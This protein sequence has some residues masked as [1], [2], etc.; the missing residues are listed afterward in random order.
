MKQVIKRVLENQLAKRGYLMI[1]QQPGYHYVPDI[2]GRS[3]HK[4]IDPRN[5]QDFEALASPI[6][7]APERKSY[8]YYDRLYI[9]YQSL[10][11][12]RHL[13]GGQM[14]EVGVFRGGG[15]YFMASVIRHHFDYTPTFYAIDT[16]E[17]HP[18]DINPLVDGYHTPGN[19]NKTSYET[20]KE[21]LSEFENVQVLKGRFEDR[22]NELEDQRFAFVHLDVDIYYPTKAGLDFFSRRLLSG[23]IIVVDDYGFTTCAGAK[24]ATDEFTA[25]HPEFAQFHL[26][27]GQCVLVYTGKSVT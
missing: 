20:V 26:D 1:R 3:A 16:F 25:E 23:G 27:T 13:K 18:D 6:V 2:Y 8:L 17:G 22:C 9:L 19:F 24:Q 5:E 15:S 10:L 14:A 12:V 11:N 7:N 21:Y 4:K